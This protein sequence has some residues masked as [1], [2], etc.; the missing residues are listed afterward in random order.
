MRCL[1]KTP[2]ILKIDVEW[3]GVSV[4]R[5]AKRVKLLQ[6]TSCPTSCLPNCQLTNPQA[7]DR[8]LTFLQIPGGSFTLGSTGPLFYPFYT[9]EKLAATINLKANTRLLKSEFCTVVYHCLAVL[10]PTCISIC[11]TCMLRA[12]SASVKALLSEEAKDGKRNVRKMI[13][14]K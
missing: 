3:R 1:S 11:F 8:L 9:L 6:Q 13:I 2:W 5:G 7:L 10:T 14:W 12:K 4:T